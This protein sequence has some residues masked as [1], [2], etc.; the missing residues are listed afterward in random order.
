MYKETECRIIIIMFIREYSRVLRLT[1][2]QYI[3]LWPGVSS[4]KKLQVYLTSRTL[5]FQIHIN[6]NSIQV[7]TSSSYKLPTCTYII[8]LLNILFFQVGLHIRTLQLQKGR[9]G[10]FFI[11]LTQGSH[12]WPLEASSLQS[13]G[14]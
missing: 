2:S 1:V 11:G 13:K 14:L 9:L 8:I 4:I 5:V 6:L 3:V 12:V 10:D 7:F